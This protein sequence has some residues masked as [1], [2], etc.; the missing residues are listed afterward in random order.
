MPLDRVINTSRLY[1]GP[2]FECTDIPATP[3]D[4]ASGVLSNDGTDPVYEMW[5]TSRGNYQFEFAH[6]DGVTPVTE[7]PEDFYMWYM[8]DDSEEGC[9]NGC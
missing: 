2:S 1:S 9:C 4:C 7:I 3:V 8:F 5:I 6:S